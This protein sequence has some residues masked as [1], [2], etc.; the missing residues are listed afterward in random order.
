MSVRV[1]HGQQKSPGTVIPGRSI[2]LALGLND[3]RSDKKDQLRG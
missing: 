3:L 2:L 1:G